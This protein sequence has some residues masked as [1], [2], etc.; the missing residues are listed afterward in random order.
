SED[1]RVYC[2]KVSD[3]ALVWKSRQLAGLSVRDY[4]PVIVRGLALVTTCPIKDFQTILGQHQEMLVQR[5]GFTRPDAGYILGTKEDVVKEQ[6]CL[7]EFL[8]AH[9]EERCFYAFNVAD[10]VEPWI[11]PILYTGGLHNPLTP[12]CVNP[13]TGDVFTQVR[14]AYGV[15]DGGG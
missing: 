4:A 11:A 7:V 2:L 9:P 14:S 10:G 15:W 13:V 6:D 8:Q 1:M 5:T 3:G 12:P